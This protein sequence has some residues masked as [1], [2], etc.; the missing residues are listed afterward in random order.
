M[1][2]ASPSPVDHPAEPVPA[3]RRWPVLAWGALWV[4]TYFAVRAA[5][6]TADDLGTAARVAIA[7]APLVPFLAFLR[8]FVAGLRDL[9]EMERRIQLEALSIAFPLT[10][11]LLMVLGLVE[12]ATPLSPADWSYRHV[13]AFL[14]LFYFAGLALAGRRYR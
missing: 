5:L 14:P 3:P 7:L 11:V 13:W 6:E 4:V 12:L 2:V 8:L 10:I 1:V 9:D